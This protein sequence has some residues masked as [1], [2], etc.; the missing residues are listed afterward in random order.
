MTSA[1]L[2]ARVII[3]ELLARGVREVVLSPGSRSAPL[4]YEVFEA[5]KIGLLR[6]HVRIDERSAGF[7]AL[8]LAKA[9]ESPVAVITTSGTAAANLHPAM[10]EAH[11]SHLPLVAVTADRPGFMI[12][13]GANQTTDQRQLFGRQVRAD[14]QL[15]SSADSIGSWRFQLA[16]L[17]AAATGSRTLNPGPVHLNV[18][19]AEPLTP[20]SEVV[21]WQQDLTVEP[22]HRQPRP[23][24]LDPAPQTVIVAGDAP[25][26]TGRTAYRLAAAADVPLLAEPSSNA[27][28]GDAALASY[29]LLLQ[30]SLAEDVERVIVFGHPTLSRPVQRLLQRSDVDL[31]TV[32]D[33]AD[34]VDPGLNVGRV[35]DAVDLEPGDPDWSD[36]WRQADSRLRPQLDQ[37]IDASGVF[38]GPALAAV[39]WAQMSAGEALVLGSSNPVRDLDL[40]PVHESVPDVYANRGLA[41][42]DGTVSTAIGVALATGRPTHALLGDLTFLHD[43]NGLIL[44]PQ[45]PRPDLRIVVAN[46]DGGSIFATLEHG[47]PA[48][49][50]AFERIFGT[51]HGADLAAVAA[52]FGIRHARVRSASEAEEA[53]AD[54]PIGI[55]MVEAVIDRR[56]RRA[57]SLAINALAADL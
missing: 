5:D 50:R 32:T 35:L 23:V 3:E 49:M 30:S 17:L 10:L 2:C 54:P 37:L 27:R 46:D 7:L 40:A 15:D 39:L 25:P 1:T 45:E 13:T 11:H 22:V 47:L 4:A 34:W 57:L 36:R 21:P 44:G 24:R 41:G 42:I 43:S 6:L 33:Y 31:V 48:H 20:T 18:A 16:R 19:F 29:R 9:S 14:A 26:T 12:N 55:E 8:G 56:G 38:T 52:S 51:A 28:R 53:L